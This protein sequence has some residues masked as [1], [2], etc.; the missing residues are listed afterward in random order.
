MKNII[1]TFSERYS[2]YSKR[3]NWVNS[4]EFIKPLIPLPCGNSKILDVCAGTGVISKACLDA[5]WQI[6]VSLDI[7]AEMLS[8]AELQ[9]PIVGD[10]HNIPFC[11]KTFDV[12][13]CRQGLQYADIDVVL[14]EFSRLAI[15]ELRLGHITREEGDN[16]DFWDQYFKIASPGRKHI[17][18]PDEL[19][20]IIAQ[21]GMI[22]SSSQTTHQIDDFFGPIMHLP[23]ESQKKLAQMFSNT[24]ES[25]KKLYS[26]S[27][28]D[29]IT[30]S[31][32]WEFLIIDM[33]K[34]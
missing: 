5:G 8:V 22:V 14:K 31:N 2:V 20:S 30:Y 7:S 29:T 3:T 18:Y 21:N 13:V 16:T 9:L 19:S 28:D 11:A 10:M 32:R 34:K 25:F 17:F 1:E 26:V 12:V 33:S 23:S 6:V 4:H 27:I 15:R 24:S